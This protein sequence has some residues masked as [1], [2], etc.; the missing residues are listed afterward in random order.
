MHSTMLI[1]RGRSCALP[2]AM[3]ARSGTPELP[4]VKP[5]AILVALPDGGQA[6]LPG[7]LWRRC[8]ARRLL[9]SAAVAV[10]ML[11]AADGAQA[12]G[13]A[14]T[15]VHYLPGSGAV[16]ASVRAIGPLDTAVAINLYRTGCPSRPAEA[17]N[18]I[19]VIADGQ[20]HRLL[21]NPPAAGESGR[22]VLCVWT[23]HDD[24]AI[25]QRYSQPVVLPHQAAPSWDPVDGTSH[26]WWWPV[27]DWSVVLLVAYV[28]IG[29]VRR[30]GRQRREI[31]AEE[32]W[33]RGAAHARQTAGGSPQAAGD[34]DR[35]EADTVEFAAGS[36][37]EQTVSGHPEHAPRP[38]APGTTGER[39]GHP[40]VPPPAPA[41]EEPR[42]DSSSPGGL[43][44][45]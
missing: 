38:Q 24:G 22:F 37:A 44:E 20:P 27:L 32:P 36:G 8:V 15:N 31:T 14:V 1:E 45:G 42:G 33:R 2:L 35:G 12:D 13:L 17:D 11:A 3:T 39:A 16:G 18:A 9:A 29:W 30:L 5:P 23:I 7:A 25:G 28:A 26:R 10:A 6:E 40:F 41:G 4:G 21:A 19:G 34:S 43:A